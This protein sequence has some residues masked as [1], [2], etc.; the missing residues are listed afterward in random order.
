MPESTVHLLRHG[1]VHNPGGIL[2]GRLP[3]FHL[4]ELGHRMAERA[5]GYFRQRVEHG[6]NISYLVASPLT[7]AQETAQPTAAALGLEIVT[8]ERIIEA[9]NRF[10]GMSQVARRLRH[11]RHWAHL[12]NPFKP[13]W[14][15][16]YTELVRRVMEAAED[17]RR[18]AVEHAARSGNGGRPEA[19]LVSH[20]LPIWVSRLAAEKK[21][22]WHDPRQRQCT[23]ASVT[24]FDFDDAGSLTGVRYAEPCADLLHGA[25]NIPGA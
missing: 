18:E 16:P 24:S 22:L 17:A 25:A 21:R 2:Y 4:S 14:G 7:R 1:E 8:D 15:E 6:A 11:P 23:L 5:A 13:S 10:E 12:S 9:E 3:H 19:V 20:Q